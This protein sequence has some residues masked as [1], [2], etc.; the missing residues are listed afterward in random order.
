[1]NIQIA[2]RSVLISGG[3]DGVVKRWDP[4]SR[5]IVGPDMG[6]RAAPVRSIGVSPDGKTLAVGS[7]DGTVR[8]WDAAT[9]GG[10][11]EFGKPKD[12]AEAYELYAVGFSADGKH[13][14]VGSFDP[15]LRVLDLERPGV[16]HTLRGHADPIKCLSRG[17]SRWLLSAGRDGSVLEWQQTALAQSQSESLKKRDEFKFR[18]GF[19]DRTPLTS[20]DTTADGGL[21]LTGGDSG[22]VQLWDGTEHVLIGARFLGHQADIGIRA[23]ALAFDGSFFVTADPSKNLVWPGPDRWADIICS[24]LVWNMSRAQWHEWVSPAIPYMPQCQGLT[25]APDDRRL[26]VIC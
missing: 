23:V 7:S 14:A 6:D 20:M 13:L 8:L 10:V 9:G 12:A 25:V 15:G 26:E 22:Q 2:G 11:R 21:I 19:R 4:V 24:K 18:L 17:G 3:D 1:M 5:T 16:E